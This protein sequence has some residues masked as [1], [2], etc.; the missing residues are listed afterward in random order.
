MKSSVERL[1]VRFPKFYQFVQSYRKNTNSD[2]LVFSQFV[3]RGDTVI[4]CGANNGYYT[5]F[6][7]ALVGK[8][9]FV[10]SFEPVPETFRELKNFTKKYWNFNNYSTSMVGLYKECSN[11]IAYIP[12]S[13]SGHASLSNHKEVWKAG[14]T[15]EISIQLTT[16]DSY[17]INNELGEINFIKIDIEGAE[18]DA[19]RGGEKTL[20]NQKPILHLEVNS[21]LLKNFNQNPQELIKFL[22]PLGYE[23]F[24]YYDNNPHLLKSFEELVASK[25]NINTNVIATP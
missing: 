18:L 6:F 25:S 3:K 12:N 2:K 24:H 13:I 1:C 20:L 16:L 5:N 19:L 14:S 17:V 8:K 11:L 15:E 7:R 22:K 10:H 23:N 4:D 21:Q 9:G